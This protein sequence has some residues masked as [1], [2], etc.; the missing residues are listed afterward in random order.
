L[1]IRNL[2]ASQTHIFTCSPK[3]W[4]HLICNG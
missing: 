4:L 1:Q 3:P 2:Y